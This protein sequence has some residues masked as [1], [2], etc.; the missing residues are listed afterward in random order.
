MTP[1]IDHELLKVTGYILHPLCTLSFT[2]HARF[3]TIDWYSMNTWELMTDCSVERLKLPWAINWRSKSEG[4][5]SCPDTSH[6]GI[7]KS[8]QKG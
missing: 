5:G 7:R 1:I 4:E 6:L 8:F 3:I 2:P